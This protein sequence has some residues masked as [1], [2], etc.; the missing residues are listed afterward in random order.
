MRVARW[1][2]GPIA[3]RSRRSFNVAPASDTDNGRAAASARI[4]SVGLNPFRQHK[5]RPSD[6]ILVA[7][8]FVVVALLVVWVVFPR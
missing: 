3:G 5:R 6:Y 2:E 7:A 8:A 4:T 1:E